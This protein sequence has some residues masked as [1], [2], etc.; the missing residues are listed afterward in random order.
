MGMT[1]TP[2]GELIPSVRLTF[3]A[4]F[5]QQLRILSSVRDGLEYVLADLHGVL[6]GNVENHVLAAV[7]TL[8]RHGHCRAAGALAG[9]LLEIHL[10]HVAA[11]YR[12]AMGAESPDITKLNAALK[13]GGMYDEELWSCIQRLGAL[14]DVW[15]D[16]S[17]CD[18][19]IDELTAF[20][21]EVQTV[22][23]RV[24]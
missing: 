7:Y 19:T 17:R 20:I 5:G 15:V 8:S 9:V 4:H 1:I 2:N 12:V 10:A 16:A 18:P 24:R 22:R 21:H 3:L 11:K 14:R 13:R 23:Q 6:Y